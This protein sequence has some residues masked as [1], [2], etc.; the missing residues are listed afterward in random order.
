MVSNDII[1]NLKRVFSSHS[2]TETLL[3]DE[4]LFVYE[5]S[6]TNTLGTE[7]R[8]YTE[9][10]NIQPAIRHF[11]VKNTALGTG[12][13]HICI[14]GDFIPYGQE[15]YN[16]ISISFSDSRPDSL[17]FNNQTFIFLELK[18][19]QEDATET[20]EDPKWKLFI[21]G[22]NQIL[23]FVTFLRDSGFEIKSYYTNIFA[24]VCFRFEP[25]F[26]VMSKGNAA[27]N[28]QIFKISQKLGFRLV[29]HNHTEIF[30]I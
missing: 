7:I 15:K 4:F 29:P 12:T 27:R 5:V 2:F 14:D 30:E 10:S 19:E 17:V 6:E 18:V 1:L 22:A 13:V 24:V 16:P 3:D 23:D 21:K 20:K 11:K 9:M 25:N 26:S 8:K 28:S